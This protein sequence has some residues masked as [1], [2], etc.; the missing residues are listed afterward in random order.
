MIS[1]PLSVFSPS[2]DTFDAILLRQEN[3]LLEPNLRRPYLD[4]TSTPTSALR[5]HF[6]VLQIFRYIYG[7]LEKIPDELG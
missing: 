5:P 7:S 1:F 4:T 6:V 3:W 2:K